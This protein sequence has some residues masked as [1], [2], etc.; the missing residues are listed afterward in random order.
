MTNKNVLQSQHFPF[1]SWKSVGSVVCWAKLVWAA[2]EVLSQR[3]RGR[4]IVGS[5]RK[6]FNVTFIKSWTMR[7][8]QSEISYT[9][10]LLRQ[11]VRLQNHLH[12]G[13][14]SCS[15]IPT[16][17][18]CNHLLHGPSH[19]IQRSLAAGGDVSERL[20]IGNSHFFILGLDEVKIAHFA[21][22]PHETKTMFSRRIALPCAKP[23][24]CMVLLSRETVKWSWAETLLNFIK[25]H[26][27]L[28]TFFSG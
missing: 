7:E 12:F 23:P 9:K 21:S 6:P 25:P 17:D 1:G 13:S 22:V 28:L 24:V 19:L 11:S 8:Q 20:H 10:V 5:P 2:A 26:K 16:Q 18:W 3:G 15:V 14:V 4:R 27:S